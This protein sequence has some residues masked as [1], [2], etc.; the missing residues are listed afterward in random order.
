MSELGTKF[1][2]EASVAESKIRLLGE[3]RISHLGS[4][5]IG[6]QRLFFTS[7]DMVKQSPSI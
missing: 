4:P 7:V 1:D 6:A 3:T 2:L 5:E